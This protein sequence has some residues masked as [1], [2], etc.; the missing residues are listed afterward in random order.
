MQPMQNPTPDTAKATICIVNYKTLDLTRLCLRSLRKHTP[1]PYEVLV[2]DNDS[3]DASTEYLRSLPW[4]RLIERRP[5]VPDP[6]PEVAHSEALD[7]GLAHCRTEFFVSLHSD[8]VVLGPGWLDNLIGRFD[9]PSVACV[10]GGK[11]EPRSAWTLAL[12]RLIDIKALYRR[13]FWD[14]DRRARYRYF[15]RTVYSAYRTEVLKREGLSF[16]FEYARRLTV[17]HL[18]YLKLK[19]R[20]Y[21]TVELSDARVRPHVVHLIHATQVLHSGRFDMDARTLNRCQ[22]TLRRALASEAVQSI[23]AD[24][25]LD[26]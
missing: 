2:V 9:H 7:L 26:Q 21:R 12:K 18:L 1:S 20:G 23:L 15:N 25:A 13:L 19:E 8:T 17:G 5:E 10:G 14:P 3:R 22:R 16:E 6:G 11:L 24:A 4:I